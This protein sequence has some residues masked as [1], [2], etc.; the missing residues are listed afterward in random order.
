M[1]S[2]QLVSG[3]SRR[4]AK[5]EAKSNKSTGSAHTTQEEGYSICPGQ[6]KAG[7]CSDRLCWLPIILK[8]TMK[9][10]VWS[11]PRKTS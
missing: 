11:A 9:C 7:G 2:E 6:G 1:A 3:Y 5:L 8:Q 4:E 10:E